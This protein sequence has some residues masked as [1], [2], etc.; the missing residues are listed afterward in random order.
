MA[1]PNY[2]VAFTFDKIFSD[3]LRGFAQKKFFD[4]AEGNC[5]SSK[6]I[7]HITVGQMNISTEEIEIIKKVIINIPAF[8]PDFSVF[9][10]SYRIGSQR[11]VGKLWAEINFKKSEFLE[12]THRIFCN[13]M[14]KN[15]IGVL[16]PIYENYH[17]HLT[18]AR[19]SSDILLPSCQIDPKILEFNPMHVDLSYG[20]CNQNGQFL[21]IEGKKWL[22]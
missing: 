15:G 9:S 11:H 17:P 21:K 20:E 7:P 10:F 3:R 4:L 6:T 2:I 16:N 19:L 22:N 12:N 18:F 1:S 8:K 13:E 5:L 14:E